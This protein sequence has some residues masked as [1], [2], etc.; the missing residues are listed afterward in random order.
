MCTLR[1]SVFWD[2]T[3]CSPLKVNRRFGGTYRLH[4]QGR[5]ISRARNQRESRRKAET[6][7]MEVTCSS[8][9]SVDFQRTTQRYIAEYR[10]LHNHSSENLTSCICLFI[11]I[12]SPVP[13]LAQAVTLLKVLGSNLG[14]GTN[15]SEVFRGFPHSS[16]KNAV[17]MPLI[18]PQPRPYQITIQ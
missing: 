1:S 6:L 16:H 10:T 3:L 2:I 13:Q 12:S 18:R 8:E 4:L 11:Y 9:T 5:G 14:S 17:I 7:K 15:Y